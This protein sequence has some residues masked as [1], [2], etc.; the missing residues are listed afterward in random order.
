MLNATV[1]LQIAGAQR[2]QIATGALAIIL[3]STI[4]VFGA[5]RR[6]KVLAGALA[7]ITQHF[8]KKKLIT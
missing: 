1:R 2:C 5:R 3:P 6:Q 7:L 8:I 4:A